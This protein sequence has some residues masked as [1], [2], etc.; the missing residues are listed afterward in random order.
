MTK[1]LDN[2]VVDTL[3]W[4][5]AVMPATFNREFEAQFGVPRSTVRDHRKALQVR[6]GSGL[7][8][9]A[10]VARHPRIE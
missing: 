9:R 6:R 7:G 4:F 2:G 3:G 10:C 8:P 1:L 5:G